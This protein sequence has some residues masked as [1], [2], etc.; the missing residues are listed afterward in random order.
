MTKASGVRTTRV[1]ATPR[2][3]RYA[4]MQMDTTGLALLDAAA[5]AQNTSAHA[6]QSTQDASRPAAPRRGSGS[7]VVAPTGCTAASA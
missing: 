5:E 2:H 1:S 3:A 7:V 4:P 6:K